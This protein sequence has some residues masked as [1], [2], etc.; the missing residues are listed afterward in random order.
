[1]P[2]K[3]Q[4]YV[5]Y[6]YED[7]R[8]YKN[9]LVAWDKNRKLDFHIR[10]HSAD[11]SIKSEKAEVIKRVISRKIKEVNYFLVIVGHATHNCEWVKWEVQKA[12]ELKKKIVAIKVS[13][14]NKPPRELYGIGAKWAYKFNMEKINNAIAKA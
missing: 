5:S 8:L 12:R 4:V 6:H 3:K 10:D 1:M 14:K 2:N 7:D 11:F 13:P 9:L